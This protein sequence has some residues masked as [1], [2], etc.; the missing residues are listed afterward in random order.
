MSIADMVETMLARGVDH[1]LIVQAVKTAE[2]TGRIANKT[3]VKP[4]KP[5]Q[6][7]MFEI[8]PDAS[9]RLPG[10]WRLSSDDMRFAQKAGMSVTRMWSEAQKF[11]DYYKDHTAPAGQKFTPAARWRN[12]VRNAL[13]F[14]PERSPVQYDSAL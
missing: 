7:D 5:S 9:R 2:T 14:K 12:W 4:K 11:I 1:D 8:D 13:D 3:P 10:D 6:I